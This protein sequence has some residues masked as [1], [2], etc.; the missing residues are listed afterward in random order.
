MKKEV[1]ISTIGMAILPLLVTPISASEHSKGKWSL[2]QTVD[3]FGDV[4]EDSETVIQSTIHGTFSILLNTS[5][6]FLS[7]SFQTSLYIGVTRILC[8]LFPVI[9]AHLFLL[10]SSKVLFLLEAYYVKLYTPTSLAYHSN[11]RAALI[12]Y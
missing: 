7:R 5:A 12:S 9:S 2:N 8:K 3:E 11:N 6:C 1:F 4:T 10:P